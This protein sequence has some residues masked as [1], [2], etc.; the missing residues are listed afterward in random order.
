[1]TI[2][3]DRRPAA[4]GGRRAPDVP[5]GLL[6]GRWVLVQGQIGG[7]GL[8][9]EALA[10]LPLEIENG[11]CQFGTEEGTV[12]LRGSV[13]AGE[14]DVITTRGPNGGRVVP[15]IFERAGG[16]LRICYDLSGAS[17]PRC[18]RSP[19]GTHL[20]L[21]TYRRA[22]PVTQESRDLTSR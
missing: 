13:H 4:I 6:N 18:F 14:L 11:S 7:V 12:S 2:H 1:M 17:R 21:A 19:P 22:A 9:A 20:F 15:A 10:Q 8:P 3:A 16:M 5:A